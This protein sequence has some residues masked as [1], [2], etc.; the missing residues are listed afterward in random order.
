[1]A[2]NSVGVA[3]KWGTTPITAKVVSIKDFPDI[4]GS[5]DVLDATDLDDTATSNIL[6][7]P[8]QSLMEFTC[9]YTKAEYEATIEHAGENL[10]YAM[11]LGNTEGSEGTFTFE[12]QHQAMLVGKGVNEVLEMRVYV[13]PKTRPV[14]AHVL[15]NVVLGGTPTVGVATSALTL[16]YTPVSPSPTPT[17][18]Y[19]WQIATTQ[20]GTYSN[21]VGATNATYTPIAGD[22]TKW[23]RCRVEA[24]GSAVGV[25]TSNSLQVSS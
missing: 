15:T 21:I 8:T 11:C 6:G 14:L 18:V 17:V 5:P 19:Q 25:F 12:G 2:I 10:Y 7:L 22:A 24:G 13:A 4:G 3:L 20:T 23:I 1:M 16:T 9:N